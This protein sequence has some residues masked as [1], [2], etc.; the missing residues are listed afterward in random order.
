MHSP[1]T[2]KR[3]F[4][5]LGWLVRESG[6]Q[7]I[8]SSLLPVAGSNTERNRQAQSINTWLCGWCHCHCFGLYGD[9]MAYTVQGLL[10]SDEIHLSQKGKRVFAHELAGLIDRALT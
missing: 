5:A 6:T 1:R 10:A 7:V 8:F 4:R 2:I 3:H 9:G